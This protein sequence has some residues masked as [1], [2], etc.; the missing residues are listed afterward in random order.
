MG[1]DPSLTMEKGYMSAMC[2]CDAKSGNARNDR[3][4]DVEHSKS[5]AFLGDRVCVVMSK[6]GFPNW[7][8][9]RRGRVEGAGGLL[10]MSWR[11]QPN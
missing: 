1:L 8:G 2:Q 3:D 11:R 10:V 4:R 7:N 5:V 9:G 6:K